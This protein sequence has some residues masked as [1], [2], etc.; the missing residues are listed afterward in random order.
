MGKKN[1]GAKTSEP[2]PVLT[3]QDQL[4]SAGQSGTTTS[5]GASGTTTSAGASG[6]TTS[7]GASGTTTGP[8]AHSE[9][10]PDLSTGDK[11]KR[12]KK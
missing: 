7:A 1:E 9:P 10:I 11:P 6:T 4:G 8:A 2:I 5:A 12:G 3:D